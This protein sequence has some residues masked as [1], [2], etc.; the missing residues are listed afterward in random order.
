MNM[1]W[2]K[3]SEQLP[4]KWCWVIM[5]IKYGKGFRYEIGMIKGGYFMDTSE[6]YYHVDRAPYWMYLPDEPEVKE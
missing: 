6:I 4:E 1:E 5:A 3:T 2:I